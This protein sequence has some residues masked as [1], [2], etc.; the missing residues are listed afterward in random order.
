MVGGGGLHNC[1][2][3]CDDIGAA[4]ECAIAVGRPHKIRVTD[5]LDELTQNEE[6]HWV[7][8]ALEPS[9]AHQTTVRTAVVAVG[10]GS[11]VAELFESLGVQ[12]VVAGGQ[13]MNPSTKELL[14]AVE[15]VQAPEVIILP[16]NKN[17]IPVAQQVDQHSTRT[18]VVVGTTSVPEALGCLMAY[19]PQSGAA[20]NAESMAQT[21]RTV[22]SGEVTQAVR[23]SI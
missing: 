6:Q 16:N 14:A 12:V 15:S 22:Q 21:A 11:G 20:G 8:E 13:S 18:V 23:C 4:I 19:D 7:V 1:H 5:L 2:I 17:I 9:E 10:V 3:H